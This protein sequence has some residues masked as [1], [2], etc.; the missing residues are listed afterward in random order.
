MRIVIDLQGAQTESRFRGIGRYSLSLAEAIARNRGEHEVILALNGLL[1]ETIEP[2]RAAFH[3]LLPQANIRV[4]HAPGP[5]RENDLSNSLR[6]DIAELVRES[7]LTSLRPDVVLVTS[8]FEGLGDDAVTSIGRFDIDTPTAVV[9][10][11]LIPLISPDTHFRTNPVHI[12]YYG[13]KI[14]S[15]KRSAALLAISESSKGEALQ[16]LEFNPDRVTNI[17]SGCD[18]R[19][20]K[21]DMT[22]EERQLLCNNFGINKPFLMYT[23]G[24]DERKNLN[25]LIEAF[26]ELPRDL[27]TQYQLVMVGKMPEMHVADLRGIMKGAG[28]NVFDVVFT[29]YVSD[30]EL[31]Q[32]YSLCQLFVFPSLHEGFGLPPLEAM[33]CGAP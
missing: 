16:A 11:D 30:L 26:A 28:L 13:R 29:S 31:M 14:D 7:F 23:G 18:S 20:H 17:S 27:R 5:T 9:L 12:G 4:W 6:R 22:D 24:A 19:F 1:P 32:L 15:L 10:Y 25:K 3:G 2:I 33:A 8:L 21:P